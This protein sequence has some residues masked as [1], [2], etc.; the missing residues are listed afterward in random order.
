MAIP[1]LVCGFRHKAL[2][3]ATQPC[4][5]IGVTLLELLIVL[6]IIGVMASLL[7]PAIQSARAQANT[8]TCK[9]HL[10]QVGM[11]L[12]QFITVKKHFPLPNQWTVDILKWMEEEPL[13][14]QFM[15]GVPATPELARPPLLR[16]AGQPEVNSTVPSVFVSHYV[17]AVD[18][19][20]TYINGDHEVRWAI[21]DR[22]LLTDDDSLTPWY[23]GPEISFA[24]QQK[25]FETMRGPHPGGIFYDHGGVSRGGTEN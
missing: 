25:M 16:C 21:H 1:L 4:R 12:G 23:V 10:R 6:V 13:S 8:V 15:N 7:F 14:M 19:P 20:Y 22:P 5:R 2:R 18:R 3:S 17:L 9:N 11:A 24:E